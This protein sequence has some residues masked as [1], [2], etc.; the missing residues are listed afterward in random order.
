MKK[1]WVY[2]III[3]IIFIFFLTFISP[4]KFD[5]I[6]GIFACIVALILLIRE[7]FLDIFKFLNEKD[8]TTDIQWLTYEKPGE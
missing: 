8:K 7:L 6:I 3:G 2:L 1:Y 4:W 5:D